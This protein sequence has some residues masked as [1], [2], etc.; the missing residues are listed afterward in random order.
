MGYGDAF[1]LSWPGRIVAFLTF[2]TGIVLTAVPIS[3]ISGNFHGEYN[4]MKR[5]KAIKQA[6]A[7]QPQ[8]GSAPPLPKAE[9]A[10]ARETSAGAGS[11][12]TPLTH[13]RFPA[14]A[15]EQREGL[16]AVQTHVESA[17]SDPFLRSV[18]QVVRNSRRTLM[19]KL[20]SAELASR[21][22]A[23]Q[24]L[25]V[26]VADANADDVAATVLRRASRT[27]LA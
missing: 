16:L 9:V 25:S 13:Q 18:L 26:L 4:Q 20:K 24:D 5:L 10:A 1:P 6:H 3:V 17:W 7:G 15:Q 2:M 11:P 19:A 12:H 8:K 21:D 22:R 14:S 27:G 23:A